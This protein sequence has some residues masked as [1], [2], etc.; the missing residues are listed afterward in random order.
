MNKKLRNKLIELFN[1]YIPEDTSDSE[2]LKE[3]N[4]RGLVDNKKLLEMIFILAEEIST[5]QKK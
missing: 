5:P 2:V 4:R 3:L 1:I